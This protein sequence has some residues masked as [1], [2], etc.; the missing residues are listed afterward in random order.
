MLFTRK[1]KNPHRSPCFL[2]N[3]WISSVLHEFTC[4][5]C[6]WCFMRISVIRTT[7]SSCLLI[8]TFVW[9]VFSH[10]HESTLCMNLFVFCLGFNFLSF[11]FL[12]ICCL[13][14]SFC[15][16]LGAVGDTSSA[17][18][19]RRQQQHRDVSGQW[20]GSLAEERRIGQ[21]RRGGG[22]VRL[23]SS[24]G[25]SHSAHHQW[26]RVSGRSLALPFHVAETTSMVQAFLSVICLSYS[27]NNMWKSLVWKQHG[28]TYLTHTE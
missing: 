24:R 27:N 12:S 14:L 17:V 1:G 21:R 23:T 4:L 8:G 6:F 2:H 19:V 11:A 9:Y 28:L 10:L 16:G 22:G 5:V 13:L 26:A 18:Q 15:L 3:F 7:H 25:R 20:P